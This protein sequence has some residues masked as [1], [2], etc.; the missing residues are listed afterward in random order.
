MNLSKLSLLILI[1]LSIFGCK[2]QSNKNVTPVENIY[3]ITINDINGQLIDLKDFKGKYILFVNVASECGFTSQYKEL[4]ELYSTYN[5][6]LVVIG[7]PCNQFGKQ[8]PGDANQIKSFCQKNYGVDFIITEKI[9]VK[10]NNQHPLYSW[11]T[12]KEKNGLKDSNVKWNFQKYLVGKNGSLID[13]YYSITSPSS[14]K[15]INHLKD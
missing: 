1:T 2:A 10:G 4:Q 12:S 6:N 14:D 3:S 9:E 11:L 8:E 13:Y 7:L 15:I 5:D